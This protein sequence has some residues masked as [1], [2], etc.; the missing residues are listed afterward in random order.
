MWQPATS[1]RAV[2]SASGLLIEEPDA[3]LRRA[4]YFAAAG[5]AP[6]VLLI[7]RMAFQLPSA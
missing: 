3:L 4:D 1:R 2:Q 7:S 6:S 5:G